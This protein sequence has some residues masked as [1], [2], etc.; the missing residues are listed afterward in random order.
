MI[1]VGENKSYVVL[2]ENDRA[3]ADA[4]FRFFLDSFD[5]FD[6]TARSRFTTVRARMMYVLSAAFDPQANALYTITV[7]NAR[8]RRLVVSRFDRR[9]LTLSAEF[10]P[11]IAAGSGLRLGRGRSLDELYVTDAAFDGSRLYALS[12]AYGTLLVIDPAR[13]VILSAYAIPGL[14]RPVGL[15]VAGDRLYVLD[16]DQTLKVFGISRSARLQPG[17]AS[18]AAN[19][20]ASGYVCSRQGRRRRG[21]RT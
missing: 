9:E 11:A 12:A 3:D 17:E 7:P 18:A 14:H 5:R 20:S 2:R 4:N 15:A 8:S 6:E 1:A 19:Q 10:T 16:E 13:Q 21:G